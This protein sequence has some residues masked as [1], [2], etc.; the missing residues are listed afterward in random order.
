MFFTKNASGRG[1]RVSIHALLP[2]L[3]LFNFAVGC[4]ATQV[5]TVVQDIGI[6]AQQAEPI[7][8]ALA[9]IIVALSSGSQDSSAAGLTTFATTAKADLDALASLCAAY[10]AHPDAGVYAQIQSLVDKLVLESDSSLLDA[11][12]IKDPVTRQRIQLAMASF[13]A[14]IH[15]IDGFVQTTQSASTVAAKAKSRAFR[16]SQ[17]A[18]YW[19]RRDHEMISRAFGRKYEAVVEHE[20]ALGF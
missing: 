11:N 1:T 16:L 10:S 12:A 2:L 8:V 4:T 3:V 14:L 18:A 17:V 7:I 6:Y 5:S 15:T 13:D 19:S 20:L 9:P